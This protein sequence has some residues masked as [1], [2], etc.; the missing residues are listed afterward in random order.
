MHIFGSKVILLHGTYN[1]VTAAW[2][3]VL[4]PLPTGSGS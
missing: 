4:L 2:H 1:Y 3:I